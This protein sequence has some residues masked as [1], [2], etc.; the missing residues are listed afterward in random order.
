MNQ[1][2]KEIIIKLIKY[3]LLFMYNKITDKN[4]NFFMFIFS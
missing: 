3:E 1:F 4:I 2:R